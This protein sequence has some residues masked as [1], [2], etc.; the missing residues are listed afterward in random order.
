M[1]EVNTTYKK[2]KKSNFLRLLAESDGKG[3]VFHLICRVTLNSLSEFNQASHPQSGNS[4]SILVY[5][6]VSFSLDKLKD[7]AK[8]PC[9]ST[10]F[11]F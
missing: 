10:G 7:S 3:G 8:G 1:I 9:L 4:I 6:F 11:L 2:E 5:S